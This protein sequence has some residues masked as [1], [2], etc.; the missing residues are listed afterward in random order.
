MPNQWLAT[1]SL[2][3][4]TNGSGTGRIITLGGTDTSVRSLP[5]VTR[6]VEETGTNTTVRSVPI[7]T[8]TTTKSATAIATTTN[9]DEGYTLNF[10][11][12]IRS[13]LGSVPVG[14]D[15]PPSPIC[16]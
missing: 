4:K 1:D 5:D 9:E 10:A 11:I 15:S 14:A 3:T 16:G 7:I 13:L 8:R 12:K 6:T 2:T